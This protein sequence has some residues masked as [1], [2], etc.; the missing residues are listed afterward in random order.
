MTLAKIKE[1]SNL[2]EKIDETKDD[3]PFCNDDMAA[4]AFRKGNG[5]VGEVDSY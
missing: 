4:D 5:T 2:Y 1:Q 3:I